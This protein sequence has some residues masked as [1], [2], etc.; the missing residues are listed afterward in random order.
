MFRRMA[1]L[2]AAALAAG[3]VA[4]PAG[5]D[6]A[7]PAY[8]DTS[9]QA[10]GFAG[11]LQQFT[12]SAPVVATVGGSGTKSLTFT[13]AAGDTFSAASLT[14]TTGGTATGAVNTGDTVITITGTSGTTGSPPDTFSAKITNSG[15][16]I[17]VETASITETA[18]VLTLAATPSL[19]TVG[20]SGPPF[21]SDDNTTGGVVF[22]A[23]GNSPLAS[24]TVSNLPPGLNG[25][26]GLG[27]L[28]PG[29]AIPGQY[30][31]VLVSVTDTAGAVA[32][33]VF[34]LKV[35]GDQVSDPGP[36]G[37]NVNPSG[38]GFDVYRQRAEVNT[39]I[40]SWA[41]TG[42]DPATHFLREAGSVSGAYR[43]EYA[44][45]GAGTGLC[46]SNP[47]GSY[48]GDPAGPT[49]LVLRGCNLSVF[50]QFKPGSGNELISVANGQIVNPNGTGAQLYTGTS[51]VSWGGSAWTWEDDA[52][53]PG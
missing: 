18:G 42:A 53:L 52:S 39:V 26:I 46:V 17:S 6:L 24:F 25:S 38:D 31:D 29:T 27:E 16:C 30:N 10:D 50:Q 44:P 51:P 9:L 43:Y 33:G 7:Q 41:A 45:A 23:S 2:A 14:D 20:L 36:Y 5:A 3:A 48:V 8:S 4:V 11:V 37:D 40:V 19:D 32:K 49:G 13:T 12:C 21:A 22:D 34:S 47:D 1:G 35:N 28:L 15:G